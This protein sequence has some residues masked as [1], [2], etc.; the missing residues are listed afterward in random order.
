MPPTEPQGSAEPRLRITAVEVRL[1]IEL[2]VE[3]EV[4]TEIDLE[5][6]IF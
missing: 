3:P 2:E 6:E 5:V 4:E 1:E